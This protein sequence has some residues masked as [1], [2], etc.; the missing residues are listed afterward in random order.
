MGG[1]SSNLRSGLLAPDAL[2]KAPLMR[3]NLDGIR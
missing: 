1:F 3:R 2:R